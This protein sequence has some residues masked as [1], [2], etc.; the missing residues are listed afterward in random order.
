MNY[1]TEKRCP[2]CDTIKP[3]SDFYRDKSRSDGHD[4][5]CKKCKL[6]NR[7][8]WLKSNPD[9]YKNYGKMYYLKN[10]EKLLAISNEY[11]KIK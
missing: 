4:G 3:I 2:K 10:R 6:K 5:H 7:E 9:Y 11:Q 1:R 8:K